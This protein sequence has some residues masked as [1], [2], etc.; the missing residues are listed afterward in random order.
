MRR[1]VP[2]FPLSPL[3]FLHTGNPAHTFA[4]HRETQS[5][6][7]R[8]APSCVTCCWHNMPPPPTIPS[9]GREDRSGKVPLPFNTPSMRKEFGVREPESY[10]VPSQG[11]V[12]GGHMPAS[13]LTDV[14]TSSAASAPSRQ[15]EDSA[16]AAMEVANR[17]HAEA[18]AA[19]QEAMVRAAAAK[20]R[21]SRIAGLAREQAAQ[22]ASRAETV[23]AGAC[24]LVSL[25]DVAHLSPPAP[26]EMVPTPSASVSAAAAEV[27]AAAAA[28]SSGG[29]PLAVQA[30][31]TASTTHPGPA[32]MMT[33]GA[34]LPS[35]AL[36]TDAI[37][38]GG[39][40]VVPVSAPTRPVDDAPVA[41]LCERV[42]RIRLELELDASMTLTAAVA[43]AH[44]LLGIVPTGA[45]PQQA[46]ATDC[47]TA[48]SSR[49]MPLPARY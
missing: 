43:T 48:A 5:F 37:T 24:D 30:A 8:R 22:A 49:S 7:A 29:T 42:E 10:I 39:D 44:E 16:R 46:R 19:V 41:P 45:L 13:D 35:S 1:R 12:W 33:A 17:A 4:H 47:P 34:M 27:A 36:A 21:A 2:S 14:A 26:A 25:A 11:P 31:G 6:V 9:K 40:V 32:A 15:R 28:A 20:E 18:A 23:A 3:F 38:P